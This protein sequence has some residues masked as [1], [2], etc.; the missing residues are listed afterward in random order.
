MF[1]HFGQG[2]FPRHSFETAI[3]VEL[4]I[5]HAHQRASEAVLA[6]KDFGVEVALD[7]VEASVD[8]CVGIALGSNNAAISDAYLQAAAGAAKAAD[9][10]VPSNVIVKFGRF[11]SCS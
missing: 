6:I 11:C 8:R 7:T 2:R 4:S 9:A 1:G 3:L 5:L 10:L